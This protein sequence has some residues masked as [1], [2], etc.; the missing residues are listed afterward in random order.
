[1]TKFRLL[2]TLLIF[3]AI[4]WACSGEKANDGNENE[5][6]YT[7]ENEAFDSEDPTKAMENA[8]KGMENAF[9][10]SGISKVEPVNFRKLKELLPE[11]VAGID[12]TNAEGEKAGAMGM[13]ISKAEGGYDDGDKKIN[14]SITDMGFMASGELGAMMTAGWLMADIDRES[15]TEMERTTKIKGYKGYEEYKFDKKSGKVSLFVGDRF[16]VEIDGRNIELDDLRETVDEIDLDELE[17]MKDE[18]KEE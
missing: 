2:F 6:N 8:V 16:I 13:K 5:G 10:E 14:I 9:E 18:G 1:M 7:E 15:D 3:S 4:M 12:R 11:E 17:S